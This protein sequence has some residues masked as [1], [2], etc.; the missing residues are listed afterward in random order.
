MAGRRRHR[1]QPERHEAAEAEPERR[2]QRYRDH[3]PYPER[4]ADAPGDERRQP[5]RVAHYEHEQ[6]RPEGDERRI[7]PRPVPF[8]QQAAKAGRD[9]EREEGHGQRVGRV[10]EKE[11][12]LLDQ[13]DLE[14]HEP[15]PERG[16]VHPGVGLVGDR[17]PDL[18]DREQGSQQDNGGERRRHTE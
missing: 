13:A 7:P 1:A 8:A 2:Q 15:R 10:A 18:P 12:E 9:E 6:A 4:P 5:P 14:E 17:A 3:H 16:E 11:G